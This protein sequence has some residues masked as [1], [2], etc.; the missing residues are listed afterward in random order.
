[1]FRDSQR[2]GR[3]NCWRALVRVTRS[4]KTERSPSW[5]MLDCSAPRA[6]L[7]A[8]AAIKDRW[9]FR[10]S[11]ELKSWILSRRIHSRWRIAI[12]G[13]KARRSN[14]ELGLRYSQIKDPMRIFQHIQQHGCRSN[15]KHARFSQ[16]RPYLCLWLCK[17]QKER[18]GSIWERMGRNAVRYLGR[19]LRGPVF[20]HHQW[21]VTYIQLLLSALAFFL[22]FYQLYRRSSLVLSHNQH[23]S[24]T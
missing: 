5:Q 18:E 16:K 24:V 23:K 6:I 9:K 19:E 1:M 14:S 15:C 13:E 17:T 7:H 3:S 8:L 2:T 20:S 4:G 10:T 12:N 21:H 11:I 22:N